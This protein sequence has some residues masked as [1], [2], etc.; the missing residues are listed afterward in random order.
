VDTKV[1]TIQQWKNTLGSVSI[2]PSIP[3]A[4]RSS[5]PSKNSSIQT[6]KL[7][8]TSKKDDQKI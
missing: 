4:P 1:K 3:L 2:A 8:I 6:S 7:P 5:T